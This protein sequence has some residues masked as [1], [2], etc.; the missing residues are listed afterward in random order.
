MAFLGLLDAGNKQNP[1]G[2]YGVSSQVVVTSSIAGFN[3]SAPG[4]WAYGPSK[5][6]ATHIAKMLS[7]V[8]PNWGIR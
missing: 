5:A 6:A 4:G 7:L 1:E 8:L 2:E 3:K